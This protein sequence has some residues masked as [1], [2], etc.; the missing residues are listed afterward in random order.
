[1]STIATLTN[2]LYEEFGTDPA[3]IH[4]NQSMESLGLDSLSIAEFVFRIEEVLGINF[5][6][7]NVRID[8][9]QDVVDVVDGLLRKQARV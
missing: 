2:L 1:M 9:L 5:P 6:D 3:T 8:T 4:P 7:S